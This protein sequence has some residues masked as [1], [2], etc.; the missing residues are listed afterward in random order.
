METVDNRAKV[1][2]LEEIYK[3]KD[4]IEITDK[5]II[6]KII[7]RGDEAGDELYGEFITLVTN[8][9]DHQLNKKEFNDLKNELISR[10][11][12]YLAG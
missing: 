10:M 12:K 8:E 9:V 7:F 4:L 11:S 1:F 3:Y 6:K 2:E 5:E